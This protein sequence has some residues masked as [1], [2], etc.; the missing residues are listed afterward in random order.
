[1]SKEIRC[2]KCDKLLCKINLERKSIGSDQVV[3]CTYT[4]PATSFSIQAK[5]SRCKTMN[6]QI[7]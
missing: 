2:I 3:K 1:M 5:C 7:I 4:S 6:E